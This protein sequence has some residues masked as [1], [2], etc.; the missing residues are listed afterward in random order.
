MAGAVDLDWNGAHWRLL[1]RGAAFWV[2]QSLGLVA[3]MHLGR[4]QTHRR[5]GFYLPDGGDR[6]DLVRLTDLGNRSGWSRL[7]I[8]GDVFHG[9]GPGDLEVVDSFLEWRDR[10]TFEVS[11]LEGNHDSKA[12]ALFPGR[13]LSFVGEQALIRGFRF[14][15]FPTEGAMPNVCGHLHPGLR[16]KD[17]AGCVVSCKAFWWSK[18]QLILPGFGSTTRSRPLDRE[19][20]WRVFASGE[21]QVFEV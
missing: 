7:L 12:E 15:H 10:Q 3:D 6:D 19:G 21:D 18:S 9:L 5:F 16:L 17:A 11:I 8:L 13:G 4:T 1:P 20:T 2:D 14:T